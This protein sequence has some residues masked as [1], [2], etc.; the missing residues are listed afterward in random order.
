MKILRLGTGIRKLM[1]TINVLYNDNSLP[2]LSNEFV[3]Q[4]NVIPS[5]LTH[6]A[7]IQILFAYLYT[8]I[9]GPSFS[10]PGFFEV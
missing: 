7:S 4:S 8:Q 5:N 3:G 6:I 9:L 10:D 1:N 2:Y